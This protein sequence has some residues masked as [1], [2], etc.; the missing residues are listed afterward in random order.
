M[1]LRIQ[2]SAPPE[3]PETY[4]HAVSCAGGIPVYAYCPPP[5]LSCQGLILCGGGDPA[6]ALY[7][8]PPS[9]S[10]PPDSVRDRA[11]LTLLTA[12]FEAGRPIL[13]ICRGLQLLNIALG[14]TLIQD[15]PSPLRAAHQQ[16]TQDTTHLIRTNPDCWLFPCYGPSFWGNSAHHQAVGQL[17]TGLQ[18]AAWSEDGTVEALQHQ[19]RPLFGVQFHPER[20]IAPYHA[21]GTSNGQAIFSHFLSL[22]RSLNEFN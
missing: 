21:P 14:G 16:P 19:T 18:P 6:P 4:P 1:T 12:F 8:Q 22:C 9:G 5:D 20:M 17:G 10:T 2:L 13:G 11:E 7:R 15:L 3:L